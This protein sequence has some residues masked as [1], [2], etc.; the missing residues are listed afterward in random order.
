[1]GTRRA[2]GHGPLTRF[3]SV[4]GRALAVLRKRLPQHL[5]LTLER[6]A[7]SGAD[8]R[9]PGPTDPEPPRRLHIAVKSP[10][11]DPPLDRVR[12]RRHPLLTTDVRRLRPIRNRLDGHLNRAAHVA[13]GPRTRIAVFENRVD[14]GFVR[15]PS[16]G[17]PAPVKHIPLDRLPGPMRSVK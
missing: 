12:Q 15:G 5:L 7:Q 2:L 16:I 8:L 13:S 9:D 6:P 10:V 11:L 1:M 14:A 3:A 17:L 4:A